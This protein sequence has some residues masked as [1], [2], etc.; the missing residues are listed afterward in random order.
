MTLQHT[1]VSAP[2]PGAAHSPKAQLRSN[3]LTIVR[4]TLLRPGRAGSDISR[5]TINRSAG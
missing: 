5:P 1:H 4:R 3:S 2:V